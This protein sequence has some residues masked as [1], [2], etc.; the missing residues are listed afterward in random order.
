MV[1]FSVRAVQL[2]AAARDKSPYQQNERCAHDVADEA[3]SLTSLVP[4]DG[5]SEV[6]RDQGTDNAKGCSENEALGL[7]GAAGRDEFGNNSSNPSMTVALSANAGGTASRGNEAQL[8]RHNAI[9]TDS[10]ICRRSKD[11][12]R[13]PNP[14]RQLLPLGTSAHEPSS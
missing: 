1:S 3:G 6:G 12:M 4:A 8:A 5:L 9:E 2:G 14:F 10:Q 11:V 13:S 7:V